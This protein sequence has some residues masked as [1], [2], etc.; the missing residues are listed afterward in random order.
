MS[1]KVLELPIPSDIFVS[2][3]EP[4]Q[5]LCSDIKTYTLIST[6]ILNR[7]YTQFRGF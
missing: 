5:Q 6:F 2:L 1:V 4:G 3:N 7:F